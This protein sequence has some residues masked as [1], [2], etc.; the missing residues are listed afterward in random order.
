MMRP[1]P[2]LKSGSLKAPFH[3]ISLA[4]GMLR[5]YERCR[6]IRNRRYIHDGRITFILEYEVNN[7]YEKFICKRFLAMLFDN[8]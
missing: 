6:L 4:E 2:G 8:I 5:E 3:R 7:V 1:C